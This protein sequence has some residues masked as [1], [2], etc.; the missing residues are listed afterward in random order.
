MMT[1]V[2]LPAAV[3]PERSDPR[4]MMGATGLGAGLLVRRS[5]V[6]AEPVAGVGAAITRVAG[7]STLVPKDVGVFGWVVVVPPNA[8]IGGSGAT[9]GAVSADV[10]VTTA[11][12]LA[13]RSSDHECPP[14]P[15]CER[16][17]DTSRV[18]V[19][20]GKCG[21]KADKVLLPASNHSPRA[22]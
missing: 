9:L 14:S 2:L 6:G 13:L 11:P 15:G 8:R 4:R 16:P 12:L 17:P 18:P 21:L 7:R 1:V 22:P 5:G 20:S 10:G 19:D 3:W